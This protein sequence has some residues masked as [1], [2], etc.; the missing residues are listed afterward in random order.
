MFRPARPEPDTLAKDI[1]AGLALA[2]FLAC[3]ALVLP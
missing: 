3:L 1:C 2:I